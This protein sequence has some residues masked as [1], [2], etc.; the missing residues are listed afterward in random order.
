MRCHF[1]RCAIPS[2]SVVWYFAIPSVVAQQTTS[3]SLELRGRVINRV[4]GEAI[5]GALVQVFAPGQKVQFTAADGTFD[6]SDLPPGSYLPSVRKPGFFNDLE[7][8]RPAGAQPLASGDSEE[9]ILKLTPEAIIYGE[10]K[11]EN[12]APLEGVAVRA[13]QWQVQNGEKQLVPVGNAITDDEGNFRLAD[14]RPGRYYLSFHSTNNQGWSNTYQSTS[15]KH[16]QE[17]Y[18][19]QFYPGVSDLESASVIEI[20]AGAQVHIPQSLSRQ[21]LFEVA[22]VVRGGDPESG[23]HLMLINAT[24]DAGQKSVRINPKTGQFRIS[25]VPEGAYL[26]RATADQR[27]LLRR[28][29]SGLLSIADE[30][31][32]TLTAAL[33]LHVHSDLS[34]LV[35]V[36]GSAISIPVQV[37]DEVSENRGTNTPHQVWLQMASKE[38]PLASVAITVPPAPGGRGVPNRFEGLSPGVYAVNGSPN[39]P[40]YIASMH[41]GSVDLLRDELTVPPG[42]VQPIEITLRDDG[43]QLTVKVVKNGQPA[44]AGVVLFSPDHPRRSRFLGSAASVSVGS[45]APGR[46]Y[47]IAVTSAENVEFHNPAAMERYLPH[48]TE[49][50]LGPR[51]NITASAEVQEREA[52]EQ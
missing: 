32:P 22:G 3:E 31:R 36:L 1:F 40:W 33:M 50:T 28:T 16:G 9:I 20:R 11:D 42:G 51:G 39:G 23:F 46:Y 29:S 6:F 24:G 15:K 38:F 47:V 37:R 27:P 26:L 21:Q 4:T 10:V 45:L 7:L 52:E 25:G 48:A 44:V 5:G 12:A 14:L 18:A 34:G 43:A 17:G 41:C 35:V 2:L 8:Q 49:V 19:T 30:N 13:Q